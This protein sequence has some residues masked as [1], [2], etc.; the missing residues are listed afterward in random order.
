[1]DEQHQACRIGGRALVAASLS[2][3]SQA[4]QLANTAA[5][6]AAISLS[7]GGAMAQD[8][9]DET[10]TTPAMTVDFCEVDQL[11]RVTVGGKVGPDSKL[12]QP[13]FVSRGRMQLQ[14]GNVNDDGTYEG[15]TVG[16]SLR[17]GE[18]VTVS[19]RGK[20]AN[21]ANLVQCTLL[22]PRS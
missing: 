14:A 21:G 22:P 5:L 8:L 16:S 10:F 9:I 20:H 4:R 18:V 6:F 19:T 15:T 12:G 7:S 2:S 1:M 13:V 17:A 11:G 3:I